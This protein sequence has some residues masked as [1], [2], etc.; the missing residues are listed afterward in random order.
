MGGPGSGSLPNYDP[1]TP[2]PGRKPRT[3]LASPVCGSGVPT[4]PDSLTGETAAAFDELAA[5]TA[6]VAFSQ[7]SQL[8]ELAASL[9]TRSRALQRRLAD[10]PDDIDLNRVALAVER[11]LLVALGKLGLT[12]RD[13]Q[14]LVVPKM[15]SNEPK[16]PLAT[17][18]ER[19]KAN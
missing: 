17:L 1:M 19:R 15:E 10:K 12:P 6:G 2:R 14:V 13:R 7:D 9:L 11:Q 8:I 18:L 4:R 5:L 3:A 16:D